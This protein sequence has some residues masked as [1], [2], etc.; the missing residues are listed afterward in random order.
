[1]SVN[2]ILDQADDSLIVPREAVFYERGKPVA[3]VRSGEAWE[4]RPVEL[5]Q[6]SNIAAAVVSG[7]AEGDL[8]AA[9]RP[10]HAIVP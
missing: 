3:F 9:E 4:Q 2:L 5:G 6:A 10:A 8:V 7:L 1:V